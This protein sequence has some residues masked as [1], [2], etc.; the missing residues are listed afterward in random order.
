MLCDERVEIRLFTGII[1]E[2]GALIEKRGTGSSV[3]LRIGAKSFD[4]LS[5]GDSVSVDDV[6]LTVEN[7]GKGE[8]TEAIR[9][10]EGCIKINPSR[11]ETAN[12]LAWLL[13]TGRDPKIRNGEKAVYYAEMAVETQDIMILRVLTP[14]RLLMQRLGD[15]K[16]RLQLSKRQ[17]RMLQPKETI[18]FMRI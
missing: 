10:W 4:N 14:W 2:V 15:L 6:C 13:A 5:P 3:R 9:E 8:V 7:A 12:N 17:L 16:R 18:L 1:E 11:W